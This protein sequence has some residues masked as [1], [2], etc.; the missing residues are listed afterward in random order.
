MGLS[1][2][3]GTGKARF[4]MDRT[5]WTVTA[6]AGVAAAVA[7]GT[8]PD[9][10]KGVAGDAWVFLTPL[11]VASA[12][13]FV[14]INRWQQ[15]T[16]GVGIVVSVRRE[17]WREPWSG[18]W[19][20]AAADH[21]RRR[22]DSCFAVQRIVEAAPPG[23][24]AQT[25]DAVRRAHEHDLDVA[26]ELMTARVAEIAESD[27]ATPVSLYVNAALPD[28][29]ALGA[30][31]KFNVHRGLLGI[32][33]NP[34]QGSGREHAVAE[35]TDDQKT[36]ASGRG[37]AEARQALVAPV[38]SQRSEHAWSDFF[39]AIRISG[40]LKEPLRPAESA[41]AAEL[42]RVIEEPDFAADPD[43]E[44]VA[45][46]VHLADIPT[47]VGQALHAAG[48]GC[49]D[50]KGR[51][52]RCRAALV[53]DGGSA[54]IPETPVDFELVT[55]HVYA[56]WRAWSRARPQYARLRPRL[57]ISAPASVAFALGW[58][59]GNSMTPVPHPYEIGEPCTSS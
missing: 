6:L 43:G 20:R 34:D 44:A 42:V 51:F 1:Q 12:V 33:A 8:L 19:I 57:F 38:V 30:K 21:A 53:I 50:A 3:R 31:F 54:N 36:A 41:T 29:F 45:L 7:A 39:P 55:R 14:V 27:P 28:A 16:R 10:I 25:R 11:C 26:C 37:D 52:A 49:L 22:H 4:A 9:V 58:L 24:D 2:E 18:Q 23:S 56:S 59:L 47:M 35:A 5:S 48:Q 40:R 32:G 15:R 17:G 46:V 13:V